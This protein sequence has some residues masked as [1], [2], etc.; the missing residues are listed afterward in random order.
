VTRRLGKVTTK[1]W[2]ADDLGAAE[3]LRGSFSDY[4]YDVHSHDRACF[5]LITSGAIRIRTR[6][7]EFLARIGDLYAIDADEPH[8]GWPIDEEGWSLR[9]LYV[10]IGRL[11]MIVDEDRSPRTPMLAGPIIRDTQLT[12]LF[13][14]V[15]ACSEADG[16]PLARAEHYLAFVTHLFARYTRSGSC[17]KSPGSERRAIRLARDFLEHNVDQNVRLADIAVAAGLPPFQLFRA[18]KQTMNMSP[19]TYQRQVRIRFAIG[20]IRLGHPLHHAAHA[21]GFADQAHMTRC[22]RS[23]IGV[24][25]GAYRDAYRDRGGRMRRR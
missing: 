14:E 19:H 20:L 12:S 16:P 2:Y 17:A 7:I 5:A 11:Q 6:G 24:T 25:P 8:A 3:L 9:T 23:T 1:I 4:S 21:A 22:F 13:R 15:H 10:D 18:F